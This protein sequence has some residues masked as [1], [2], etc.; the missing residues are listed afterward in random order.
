[1]E[2]GLKIL[3]K[4]LG[5]ILGCFLLLLLTLRIVG[6][7]PHDRRPGL[8]L[9]GEVATTPVTD[10]SFTDKFENVLVETRS[11]YGIPH[12]VTTNCVAHQGQFYLTSTYGPGLQF[13]R[14]RLWNKNIVRDPRVRIKIGGQLYKGTLQ[15]V[16]DPS[17]Q[18][19]VLKTKAKK[20]PTMKVPAGGS[21]HVFHFLPR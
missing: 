16:T 5:S 9:R 19:V 12:S 17:E 11:W 4:I 7:E 2:K 15:V 3:A 10:W 1:L 14:D 8:W 13:P 21:V 18:E 6:L 20:Y